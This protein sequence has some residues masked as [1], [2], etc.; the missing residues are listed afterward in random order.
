MLKLLCA[1]RM[2]L[3]LDAIMGGG[4]RRRSRGL[5]VVY[6]L[7]MVYLVVAL[8]GMFGLGFSV[9]VPL[10]DMGLSWL[11]FAL[12]GMAA[13]AL[14]VGGTVLMAQSQLYDARDNELLLSLP[15]SPGAILASRMLVLYAMNL[16]ITLL[17]LVPAGVVYWQ[18]REG[19]I[20]GGLAI[21]PGAVAAALLALA[22]GCLF[23]WLIGL[24]TARMR[25][26][27]LMT[28]L[29]SLVL[30][31]VYFYGYFRINV[32]LQ[33]ILLSGQ[34]LAEKVRSYLWLFYALGEGLSG[35]WLYLVAFLAVTA[36]V[37]AG[38][39][40]LLSK[41]FVRIATARK[42]VAR[43]KYRS[44]NIRCTSLRTALLK[45]ELTRFFTCPIYLLNSGIGILMTIVA[46]AAV[47]IKR[48]L[49]LS[50]ADQMG[51]T[52]ETL[53]PFFACA[54]LCVLGST[55]MVSAPSVSLEG[56]YLWVIR[57]LPVPS[58]DVLRA[59]LEEHVVLSA[60]AVVFCGIVL[61]WAVGAEA[62]MGI[63]VLAVPLLFLVCTGAWG[64]A[65]NLLLP[66]LDWVS[67]TEPVKQGAATLLAMLGSFTLAAAIAVPYPLWLRQWMMPEIYLGCWLVA[68][69][70]MTVG[71]LRWI[72]TAGVRRFE[73]L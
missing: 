43:V 20:A 22:L 16:L 18:G 65:M 2:R 63:L 9:L 60:P 1:V 62:A 45:R 53:L 51:M 15:L 68:M 11:Y 25:R 50:L 33:N 28:V 61:W 49:L 37:S 31:A 71:L 21:L 42:P 69:A 44:E 24:V 52:A 55:V 72:D 3:L 17:V 12:A 34:A 57:S 59:K 38:A 56:R 5:A 4:R 54:G 39:V 27:G 70:V 66:R 46:G 29:L 58:R 41:T 35:R 6:A 10:G 48:E 19:W 30:L 23:G 67:E 7:L 40:W 73:E 32:L 14:S 13:V 47:F 64:L 8:G 36:A 26:R